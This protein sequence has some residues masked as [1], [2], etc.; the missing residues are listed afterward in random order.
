M[1]TSE[2]EIQQEPLGPNTAVRVR[3]TVNM[4]NSPK[5]RNVLK[6]LADGKTPGVI[7][8]FEGA[9]GVDTSGL[10]TLV[11]CSQNMQ[12]YGG[13]LLVAALNSHLADAYSLVDIEGAF[14]IFDTEGDA[15]EALKAD[16]PKEAEQDAA[17]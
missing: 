1:Q 9:Q 6:K 10:A 7:V 4:E 11:E 17:T 8:S 13:R 16:H 5:L 3:G 12:A 15:A 2:V 14:A